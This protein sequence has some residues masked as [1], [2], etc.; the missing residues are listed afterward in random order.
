MVQR[1]QL[2]VPVQVYSNA[3]KEHRDPTLAF[4]KAQIEEATRVDK[5]QRAAG[6]SGG[7]GTGG[8]P[9]WRPEERQ[10]YDFADDARFYPLRRSYDYAVPVSVP[11]T[12]ACMPSVMHIIIHI[13]SAP[14]GR[15]CLMWHLAFGALAIALLSPVIYTS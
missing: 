2:C 11:L 14:A 7:S 10:P 9:R 4:S 12:P 8:A 5:T 15:P 13:C 6:G 1:L 3:H